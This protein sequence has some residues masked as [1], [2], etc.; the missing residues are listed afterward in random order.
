[1]RILFALAALVSAVSVYG[2]ETLDFGP[3]GSLTL[4]VLGDWTLASTNIGGVPALK[5][6]PVDEAVNANME[7]TVAFPES[8]R[9]D[10]KQRLRA[11]VEADS[12]VFASMSVE[13]KAYA[14][15][16]PL[17]SGFG[18]YCSFTDPELR[19]KPSQKGNYKVISVGLI[20]LAPDVL[21]SFAI[22]AD[23]FKTEQYQQ[24]LAAIEGMEFSPGR[25]R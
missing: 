5:V 8:D 25:R 20:R 22:Q 11:K 9:F 16:L 21:V 14:R 18:F 13:G 19:G 2:Q 4:F 10:T 17:R 3:R 24:L 23:G 12:M 15:E 6:L 7:L 1:M